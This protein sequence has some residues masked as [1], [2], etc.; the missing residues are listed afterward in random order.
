MVK[1]AAMLK[2]RSIIQLACAAVHAFNGKSAAHWEA[3]ERQEQSLLQQALDGTAP[4]W[5]E[6][7][8]SSAC[9][10][11][12]RHCAYVIMANGTTEQMLV[13]WVLLVLVGPQ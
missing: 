3:I 1:P 9:P 2:H 5:F 10:I 8:S 4:V 7:H 6:S 12:L 11:C 13:P